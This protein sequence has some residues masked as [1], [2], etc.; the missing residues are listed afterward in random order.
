MSHKI[1]FSYTD[2][3][4]CTIKHVSKTVWSVYHSNLKVLLITSVSPDNNVDSSAQRREFQLQSLSRDFCS[5]PV[6]LEGR[7]VL[8]GLKPRLCRM[9]LWTYIQQGWKT[10]KGKLYREVDDDG[11]VVR[12]NWISNWSGLSESQVNTSHQ[13]VPCFIICKLCCSFFTNIKYHI[14]HKCLLPYTIL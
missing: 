11:E 7:P 10:W 3:Y 8:E 9:T 4:L 12:P 13:N 1:S 14:L 2:E 5:D 6:L